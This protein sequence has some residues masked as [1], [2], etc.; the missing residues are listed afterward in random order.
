MCTNED[1]AV[2]IEQILG[3]LVL[4]SH[5]HRIVLHY[6]DYCQ[7]QIC[8]FIF[9]SNDDILISIQ[10]EIHRFKFYYKEQISAPLPYIVGTNKALNATTPIQTEVFPIC[11]LW[12]MIIFWA[13]ILGLLKKR[14][15]QGFGPLRMRMRVIWGQGFFLWYFISE[16]LQAR[17]NRFVIPHTE[18]LMN[19]DG[20]QEYWLTRLC[21]KQ[22]FEAGLTV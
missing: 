3:Q 5:I 4:A 16:S 11:V 18:A 1:L 22:N 10:T 13:Q 17:V 20:V 21:Y 2:V 6:K 8:R 15:W 9:Y 7:M 19:A 12:S 14:V